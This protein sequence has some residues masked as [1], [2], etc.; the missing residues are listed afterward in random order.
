MNSSKRFDL[1]VVGAGVLG[2]FHAFHAARLGKRVLLTEKDQYPSQATVR[3]FGQV[4]PSGMS[5][6]WFQFG[7][8]STLLYKSIQNEFNIG[9]R[10]MGSLY[11]ASDD[12]EQTLLHELKS[13]MDARSYEC[14]LLSRDYCL[15]QWPALKADY[16][17]EAL[18][19][20]QEVS[21]EPP[22]TIHRLLE[23][24]CAKFPNLTYSPSTTVIDC[25]PGKADVKIVTH[26][27]E[28]YV[29]DKVIVCNGSDFN[30]LFPDLF[31]TSGIEVSKLQMLRTRPM[32][33]VTLEGNILTG[34][35]IRRYE[36]FAE[37]PSY[38]SIKTPEHLI[39]LKEW[40]IHLLFKKGVDGSIII[41][42]S[43]EYA[44]VDHSNDLG[45]DLKHP[46]NELMLTEAERIVQFNVRNIAT[47]WA[48]F[49]A[50]HP[51]KDI[52]EIDLE[53]KIHIRTAI[54]GKGMTSSAG[55]AEKSIQKIFST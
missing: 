18:F 46:V 38:S 50:Q 9:I 30:I 19:F 32:P 8:S 13:V 12:D 25:I 4:V 49:Y 47:S 33:D 52:V 20:P 1:V 3:N 34:L 45:F 2:T 21:A 51:E 17:K 11:I 37:L 28:V 53:D 55:Y 10:Q 43:H 36:S 35:T 44:D 14:Q 22:F 54:G 40:G 23:Y 31:R 29:A 27:R 42:D 16:C 39:T 6:D 48:G 26:R 15:Q 5:S 7:V 24:A 41:G